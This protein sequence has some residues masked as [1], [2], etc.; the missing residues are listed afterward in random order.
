MQLYN[1]DSNTKFRIFFNELE[2]NNLEKILGDDI[3]VRNLQLC[4]YIEETLPKVFNECNGKRVMVLNVY[5]DRPYITALVLIQDINVEFPKPKEKSCLLKA[6]NISFSDGKT[7][8][9]WL[10]DKNY[11]YKIINVTS[12]KI[13]VVVFN[14]SK[15]DEMDLAQVDARINATGNIAKYIYLETAYKL[16]KCFG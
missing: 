14:M 4:S 13:K 15:K 11:F 7:F 5:N 6:T 16:E 12:N 1:T 9:K 3:S 2:T 10:Y 8:K